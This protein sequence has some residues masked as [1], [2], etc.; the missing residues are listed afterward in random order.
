[1]K[2]VSIHTLQ[3]RPR[4]YSTQNLCTSYNITTVAK[5]LGWCFCCAGNPKVSAETYARSSASSSIICCVNE[6]VRECVYEWCT[7]K[8]LYKYTKWDCFCFLILY[9]YQITTDSERWECYKETDCANK[10]KRVKEHKAWRKET[11][12]KV[13]VYSRWISH[14]AQTCGKSDTLLRKK[15]NGS[16]VCN[17]ATCVSERNLPRP[18]GFSYTCIESFNCVQVKVMKVFFSLLCFR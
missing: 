15:M 10:W 13:C 8:I 7:L 16:V 3:I 18:C 17:K 2:Q 14:L 4:H 5:H 9:L 12:G 1:M 6:W 11:R